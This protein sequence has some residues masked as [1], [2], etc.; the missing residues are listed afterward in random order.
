MYKV[1]LIKIAHGKDT[2]SVMSA[3]RNWSRDDA[4]SGNAVHRGRETGDRIGI[5][6][7]E[8]DIRVSRTGAAYGKYVEERSAHVPVY[9]RQGVAGSGEQPS[10][11]RTC[12]QQDSAL[13]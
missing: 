10:K 7:L 12:R 8:E 9:P 13:L 2:T 4:S 6:P 3:A 11:L 5:C 1:A